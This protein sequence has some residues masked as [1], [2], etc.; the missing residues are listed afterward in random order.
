VQ[1]KVAF[2]KNRL[3]YTCFYDVWICYSYFISKSRRIRE[4]KK[5]GSHNWVHALADW[6]VNL[7]PWGRRGWYTGDID[8]QLSWDA[9]MVPP[10]SSG[11]A[12]KDEL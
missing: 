12:P 4:K 9:D 10:W 11:T 2:I 3:C 6:G 1:V 8:K 5:W 7:T